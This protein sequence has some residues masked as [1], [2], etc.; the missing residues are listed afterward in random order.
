METKMKLY[1]YFPPF[2]SLIDPLSYTGNRDAD[3]FII[4]SNIQF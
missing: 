3:L 2:A 1:A 4:V